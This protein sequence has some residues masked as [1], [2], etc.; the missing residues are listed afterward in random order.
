MKRRAQ[1]GFSLLELMVAMAVFLVVG[2]IIMSAVVQM[3]QTQGTIT[4]RTEMHSSVRSATEVLQQEIGQAGRIGL[5]N[6]SVALAAN[7]SSASFPASVTVSVTP[8]T[9]GMYVGMYL[10]IDQGNAFEVVQ[11]TGF[12]S[13]SITATFNSPH[14]AG[15]PLRVSGSFG[16]GIIPPDANN[17]TCVV[18]S[19]T[20]LAFTGGSTCNILKLYGDINHD[21]NVLYVQYDCVPG[22]PA[23]P[24]FLYRRQVP[25]SAGALP[26]L[27]PDQ[28]LLNNVLPN[29]DG[30]AC[31][32]YQTEKVTRGTLTETFVTDVA[33]T[34]TVQTQLV[35]P[36]TNQYQTETKALLNVTP[37]NV[38]YVWELESLGKIQRNQPTPANI[39]TTFLGGG[40]C[41]Y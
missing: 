33:V 13:N 34:L 24:G 8:D 25:F 2:G 5:P 30:F 21:G 35:D 19:A 23:S 27:S 9:T 38:F 1:S 10:D 4:N 18:P 26:A 11:V 16:T 32:S 17:G 3:M 22:T 31:F 20:Y 29:P 6:A 7:V 41:P 36:T 12:S 39:C 14:S 40:S 28:V 37:R 15:D